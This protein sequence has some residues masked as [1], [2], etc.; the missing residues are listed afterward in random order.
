MA[1]LTQAQRYTIASMYETGY[2][3]K[4][5]AECI[6]VHKSTISREMKRNCDQRNK[7]YK[8]D[9]AE[10]KCRKRHKEKAKH[11]RFT[12]AIKQKA[13]S[14]LSTLQ[15]S[16]EQIAGHLRSNG[17]AFVS[18]ET[19]YQ[20]IWQDKKRGGVLHQHLRNRGR[21]Y[22][23]RGA[24]K[25]KRGQIPN[26]RDISL[27]PAEV[28]KKERFGDLEID[29]II[30]LNH[31]GAILTIN[32]RATGMVKIRKLNGK[33][34]VELAEMTD[35]A[36]S[37]WKPYLHTI[38]ADNGKEFSEHEQIAK[39]LEIDFYFAKPYH[40]WERGANENLN[41]LIRQY[42]PKKTDFSTISEAMI[43]EIETKL[44]NRPRKRFDYQTPVQKMTQKVAFIT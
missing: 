11:K 21:R 20:Y 34:A 32:D 13:E 9:L 41:R 28:E 16:P 7:K 42:I 33:N 37:D 17:L 40:S 23:K 31:Q 29:T 22:G 25:D 38:T 5:I 6:G 44:N 8:A 3:K 10:T 18:H 39:E 14:L 30:G 27:R 19:L 12:D 24:L 4:A 1:Q 43:A 35:L 2:S 26:R 15:Y 36:L